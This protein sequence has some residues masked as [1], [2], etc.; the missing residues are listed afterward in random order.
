MRPTPSGTDMTSLYGPACNVR[1]R[2][3]AAAYMQDLV[4]LSMAAN[5]LTEEAALELERL[6]LSYYGGYLAHEDRVR[7]EAL[8][9]IEHPFFGPATN[10]PVGPDRAFQ[11]GVQLGQASRQRQ[12]H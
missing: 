3:D 2:E 9:G 10:G 6:N 5:G 8:F 12:M 7:L 1:T 4:R 11:I